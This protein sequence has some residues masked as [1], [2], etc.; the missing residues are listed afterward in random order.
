MTMVRVGMG[1]ENA[2]PPNPLKRSR[3]WSPSPSPSRLTAPRKSS[4]RKS[5]N[6]DSPRLAKRLRRSKEVS[7]THEHM[8]LQNP[9]NR[10][11][12]KKEAKKARRANRLRVSGG[13]GGVGVGMDIDDGLEFTFMA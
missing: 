6:D 8:A 4:R 2:T 10:R 9:I 3:S 7:S 1:A 11:A 13:E 12:L 5:A